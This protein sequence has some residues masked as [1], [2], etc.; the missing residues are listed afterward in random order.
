[1]DDL[2]HIVRTLLAT[3]QLTHQQLADLV[4]CSASQI[5][6]LVIGARGVQTSYRIESR[7]RDL[8]RQD[9]TAE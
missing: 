5:G 6:M 1:M 4:P 9:A 2:R 7:L 3:R 8:Y